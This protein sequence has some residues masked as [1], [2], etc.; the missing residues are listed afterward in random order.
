MQPVG[1]TAE[2][3]VDA[4]VVAATNRRLEAEVKAGRFREDLF[5]RLNV[6]TIELPPLRERAEDIPLLAEHF[7][8]RV[9]RGAGP[10]QPAL[11]AGG[12]GA[13]RALLASRATCASCR[14]SSS[15]RRRWRTRTLLGPTTLPP[16][17]RGEP[18]PAAQPARRR[19]CRRASRSSATWT[20]AER[21][22]PARG[23]Q[24][25]GRRED[26]RRGAARADLP[27]LP[28]PAG[29]ARPHRRAGRADAP[30]R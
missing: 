17:L 23:A 25:G 26:A 19:R 6:I 13:A 12:A 4:R 30:G 15:A 5:Y 21:R 10:A 11:L 20:T 16:A 14:T 24:A 7:L 1:S 18:E 3:P 8:A 28:L 29:Q 9:A 27:L 22:L 2:V